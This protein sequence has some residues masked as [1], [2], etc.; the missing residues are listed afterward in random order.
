MTSQTPSGKPTTAARAFPLTTHTVTTSL[1]SVP[2]RYDETSAF[3]NLEGDHLKLF[4]LFKYSANLSSITAYSARVIYSVGRIDPS[5][6]PL[7]IP[8]ATAHER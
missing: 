6:Y 4:Q 2:F 5:G 1:S 7:M 8:S 3:S